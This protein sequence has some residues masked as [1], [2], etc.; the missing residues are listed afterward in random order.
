MSRGQTPTTDSFSQDM[1]Q[2]F[3]WGVCIDNNDKK[4]LGRVRV[5][6]IN[7]KINK[8]IITIINLFFVFMIYLEV[9]QKYK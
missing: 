6:P 9:M 1:T 8:R 5:K 4:M 2:N 3:Y 7:T